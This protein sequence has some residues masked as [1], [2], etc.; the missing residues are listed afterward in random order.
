MTAPPFM[1][2]YPSDYLAD[3]LWVSRD[4]NS[5]YRD[6][7]DHSWLRGGK[8][9][10]DDKLLARLTRCTDAEWHEL[11]PQVAQFFKISHG[12]WRQKRLRKE[13]TAAA[14]LRQQQS[15][16]GQKGAATR[17]QHKTKIQNSPPNGPPNGSPNGSPIPPPLFPQTPFSSSPTPEPD[18][19]PPIVPPSRGGR[20]ARRVE[21]K[22][23]RVV[24]IEAFAYAAAERNRHC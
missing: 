4:V 16:G 1:P 7:L 14:K 9:P 5:A 13:F 20:G 18:S 3:T 2:W 6:L 21:Q 23:P 10:D 22:S 19:S 8:L 17:W 24:Q 11:R 12:F 15:E